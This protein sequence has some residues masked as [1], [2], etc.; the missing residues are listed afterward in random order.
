MYRSGK[1]ID[2]LRAGLPRRRSLSGNELARFEAQR[3][4]V[5]AEY[6]KHATELIEVARASVEV[7]DSEKVAS[8]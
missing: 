5:D 2:P 7:S 1:Y 4:R 3:D 6:A 8:D